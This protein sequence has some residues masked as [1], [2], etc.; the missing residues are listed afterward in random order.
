MT[1]SIRRRLLVTLLVA[2]TVIWAVV[3]A[4]TYL[5]VREQ[6]TARS[7]ERLAQ[8]A[9]VLWLLYAAPRGTDTPAA[10]PHDAYARHLVSRFGISYAFQVWNGRELVA[11]SANAPATRMAGGY[12]PSTG[13]LG[14]DDWRFYY[15]V[16]ALSGLDVI[17][18]NDLADRHRAVGALVLGT[19][20]PLL[21]GLPLLAVLIVGAVSSGLRPLRDV[22][23]GL[24]QRR[25]NTLDLMPEQGAP[26]EVVPLIRALNG[27]LERV[28]MAVAGERRFTAD[29]SHELRTPLAALKTQAQLALRADSE[30]TRRQALN[31]VVAGVDRATH[32]VE[33][34]L[35]LARLDPDAAAVDAK[36]VDL[37]EIAEA[38]IAEQESNARSRGIDLMLRASPAPLAGH[39]AALGLLIRNLVNNAI[40]Y[41]PQGGSVEVAVHAVAEVVELIVSDDGPGIPE[42]ERARVF[43]RFY[44]RPGASVPGSGL[45]LSIVARVA[46]VH[47]ATIMLEDALA[48]P[49]PG[50]A[51]RGLRVRLRFPEP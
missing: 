45:G 35:T 1:K 15:R 19:V 23:D 42:G 5:N 47:H 29:A 31:G 12:G 43:D 37:A 3:V 30:A 18:G 7:D 25:P 51:G 38:V 21:A 32:L 11:R 33:Q 36:P 28:Q 4:I 2:F 8:T 39:P 40:R 6:V 13:A 16:D 20:W 9:Q 44:R 22:A 34:L 49:K 50:G 48:E 41:T 24:A 17:V 14:D 26:R 46:E 27:L 10:R